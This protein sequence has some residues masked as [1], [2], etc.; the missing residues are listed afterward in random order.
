M[1][2]KRYFSYEN[3][4]HD[5]NNGNHVNKSYKTSDKEPC[6]QPKN[7]L[8]LIRWL[9]TESVGKSIPPYKINDSKSTA[10]SSFF[11]GNFKAV[12]VFIFMLFIHRFHILLFKLA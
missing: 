2:F 9:I 11:I 1:I 8:I 10:N 5:D 6:R 7:I 4:H 3:V 12:I